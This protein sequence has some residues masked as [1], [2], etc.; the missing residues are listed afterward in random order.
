MVTDTKDQSID[1]TPEGQPQ[2][3]SSTMGAIHEDNKTFLTVAAIGFFTHSATPCSEGV[4]GL[5]A[6]IIL[7]PPSVFWIANTTAEIIT[8]GAVRSDAIV[9]LCSRNNVRR[10]S[11]NVVSSFKCR[12][13]VSRMRLICDLRASRFTEAASSRADRSLCRWLR[14]CS[15]R[16]FLQGQ[17]QLLRNLVHVLRWQCLYPVAVISLDYQQVHH[18]DAVT[19][20]PVHANLVGGD[21]RC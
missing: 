9:T 20:H 6:G 16:L 17:Q 10:L 8:P 19:H 11:A 7:P 14:T 15:I 2:T 1:V 5:G 18:D 4:V 21:R 13:T 12:V 3:S